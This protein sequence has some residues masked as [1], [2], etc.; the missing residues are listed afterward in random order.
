[1]LLGKLGLSIPLLFL[2]ITGCSRSDTRIV[3]I[4]NVMCRV[5]PD[6]NSKVVQIFSQGTVL[7]TKP[8]K[9]QFTFMNTTDV[10]HEVP[11]KNCFVFGGLLNTIAAGSNSSQRIWRIQEV[12][13]NQYH[14]DEPG[15]TRFRSEMYTKTECEEAIN[16]QLADWT[17]MAA[18]LARDQEKRKKDCEKQG[19][20]WVAEPNKCGVY[21]EGQPDPE[22]SCVQK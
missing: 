10:W 4:N 14:M 7:K 21:L 16:K 18:E 1:M 20:D 3:K 15:E 17:R 2:A 5:K 12:I 22:L 13:R 9:I 6:I 11:E 19:I 8:T